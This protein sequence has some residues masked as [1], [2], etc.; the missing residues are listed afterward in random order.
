M[1]Q[2]QR[3]RGFTL[4]ELLVVIAI[5]AVLIAL[6]LPAVQAAREAARRI[7]C[8]NNMKQIG[9]AMHN[10]HE[11]NNSFP[12]GSTNA[13]YGSCVSNT[14]GGGYA[15]EYLIAKQGWSALAC[16]LPYLGETAAYNAINF[17][18]GADEGAPA[19]GGSPVMGSI[20]FWVNST[21]ESNG[22]KEFWCPS[23]PLAGNGPNGAIPR[24]TNN[25]FAS[26]GTST[27][28]TNANKKVSIIGSPTT[29]V[30]GMQI[31]K[32]IAAILDGTSNT[33]AFAEST[34]S[35][36]FAPTLPQPRGIGLKSVAASAVGIFYDA[37][38][39]PALTAQALAAC[40]T[41]FQTGSG[42]VA[43]DNAR[44]NDWAHGGCAS[45]LMNTIVTPSSN[46]I[47][48]SYCDAYNTG[49]LS[50]F[51]NS[52][53]YHPGGTN[54]LFTDGSVKAVKSTI[55]QFVWWAL[56]TVAN[57]EVVSADQY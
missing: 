9:I 12:M 51:E 32:N 38:S 52:G 11:A 13:L 31:C 42:G 7:Q 43:F 54:V 29:G 19:G 36:N 56:G 40:T 2:R 8:V 24:N 49:A 30:F 3:H 22:M 57:G 50:I 26:V 48:W 39:S 14:L 25:Y 34:I 4:I 15:S 47:L 17:T 23:D 18:F 45:S 37:S 1:R 28:Q 55:S 53:S 20:A 27:N 41:S 46:Q 10:Y 33:V 5:I 6:L 21:V 44:G 16:M 35:P